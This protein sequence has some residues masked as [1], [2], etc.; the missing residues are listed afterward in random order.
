MRYKRICGWSHRFSYRY[1]FDNGKNVCDPKNISNWGR[2]YFSRLIDRPSCHTCKFTNYHRSGD[3]TIA[4]FWDDQKKRNDLHSKDGT[5]LLLVNS[6][7]GESLIKEI[8]STLNIWPIAQ[9]ET[10]QPCLENPTVKAPKRTDFWNDYHQK[11]FKHV[12]R[13]YFTDSL[14]KRLKQRIKRIAIFLGL[15]KKSI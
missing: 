5:S 15:W 12:Y 7:K 8:Q 13:K 4:D 3:F 14:K 9:E 1:S 11:G 2:L 6:D 10:W